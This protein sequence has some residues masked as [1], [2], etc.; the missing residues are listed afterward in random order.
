MGVKYVS[1]LH[2]V[3]HEAISDSNVPVT[4][5][6]SASL[7]TENAFCVSIM[8]LDKYALGIIDTAQLRAVILRGC[9]FC[10]VLTISISV[11]CHVL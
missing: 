9:F 10:T 5:S 11:T 4:M 3:T 8:L 6:S 7:L 1:K 2:L